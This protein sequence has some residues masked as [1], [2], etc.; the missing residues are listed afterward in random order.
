VKIKTVK[1]LITLFTHLPFFSSC[2]KDLILYFKIQRSAL[3]YL[4]PRK[5]PFFPNYPQHVNYQHN[6]AILQATSMM[7]PVWH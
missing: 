7:L 1:A 6:G 3:F 4:N 5:H 2:C